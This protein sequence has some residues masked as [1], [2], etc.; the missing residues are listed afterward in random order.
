MTP[1]WTFTFGIIL[2][3]FFGWYFFSDSDRVKRILGTLLTVL[4]A[5]LCLQAVYPP[6]D[7]KTEGGKVVPGKIP[8]GLDLRGGTSFLIRLIPEVD[9]TSGTA[10]EI[11]P[12]MVETAVET[13]RKRVDSLGTSEPIIAPQ[14]TDR[15]LVQIPG[16]DTAK[17][18]E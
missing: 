8:L 13:I 1:E 14:G 9:P 5:A 3:I 16:L 12:E 4:F 7:V 18:E 2:L 11:S 15:I 6:F 10:R 17:L